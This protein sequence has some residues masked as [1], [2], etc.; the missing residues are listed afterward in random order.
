MP[1]RIPITIAK[2]FAEQFSCSQVI[3]LAFDTGGRTHV[4]TYGKT[5][6]DCEQAAEGGNRMKRVMGWPEEL[7]K[8]KPARLR[9]K[10]A[11]AND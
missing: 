5:T 11:Q 2:R 10:E 4:I 9:Q 8:A 6:K 7:C 3:I 1:K